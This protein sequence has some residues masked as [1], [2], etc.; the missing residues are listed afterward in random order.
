MISRVMAHGR[1]THVRWRGW[2]ALS[3][4]PL[5]I[6]VLLL[7]AADLGRRL[8]GSLLTIVVLIAISVLWH[9][10]RDLLLGLAIG[11]AI[12]FWRDMGEGDSGVALLWPL[13]NHSFQYPHGAYVAVIASVV[14]IAALR[15][16]L[17]SRTTD[18]LGRWK[19]ST[20]RHSEAPENT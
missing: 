11:L 2:L 15:C 7:A 9:R 20:R 10:R 13:S 12:H 14:L 8:A 4:G 17:Q 3:P 5:G 6:A 1:T 16:A 18:R 19:S